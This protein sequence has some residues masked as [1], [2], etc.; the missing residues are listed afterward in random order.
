MRLC[1]GFH[2]QKTKTT[3]HKRYHISYADY[4]WPLFFYEYLQKRTILATLCHRI[5]TVVISAIEA[6][7][8]K[9]NQCQQ[10]IMELKAFININ[11]KFNAKRLNMPVYSIQQ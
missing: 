7:A 10:Q 4:L 9:N 5:L 8:K 1:K 2:E 3:R 11:T 6:F